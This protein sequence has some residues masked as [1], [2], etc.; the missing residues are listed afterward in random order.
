M[1]Q[2]ISGIEIQ[3]SKLPSQNSVPYQ[4]KINQE[5]SILVRE[6]IQTMSMTGEIQCASP[7]KGEFI[8][9]LFLVSKKDGGYRPVINLKSL[10]N[11]LP[12]AIPLFQDGGPTLSNGLVAAERLHE[13]NRLKGCLLLHSTSQKSSSDVYTFSMGRELVWISVSLF[14]AR[15]SPP[16]LYKTNGNPNSSPTHT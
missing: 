4:T 13:Q 3:F 1:L 7:K 2:W 9:N 6:E 12:S 16:Y 11:F 8:R 10:N 14:W 15:S 5:E